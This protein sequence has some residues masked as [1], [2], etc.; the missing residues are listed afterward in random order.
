M[1]I[2]RTYRGSDKF[3]APYEKRAST[4]CSARR[5]VHGS[6]SFPESADYWPGVKA[7]S[8]KVPLE[9]SWG[10][11]AE[12]SGEYPSQLPSSAGGSISGPAARRSPLPSRGVAPP[13]P[14]GEI[15]VDRELSSTGPLYPLA[16]LG[17]T[18]SKLAHAQPYLEDVGRW[19]DF[20]L[21]GRRPPDTSAPPSWRAREVPAPFSTQWSPRLSGISEAYPAIAHSRF[22]RQAPA[23][24]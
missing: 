7:A 18:S 12:Q 20:F 9:D 21:L 14:L 17:M 1:W 6:P 23:A 10:P 24:L 22:P 3:R 11:Q 19:G 15:A 16:V 8:R 13:G 4:V 5:P 2:A